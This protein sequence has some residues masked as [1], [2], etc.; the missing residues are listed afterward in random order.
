MPIDVFH[1]FFT[2]LGAPRH[3][4]L[5]GLLR[6]LST[7]ICGRVRGGSEN[8]W[9]GTACQFLEVFHQPSVALILVAKRND[10]ADEDEE[11]EEDPKRLAK[12]F[13]SSLSGYEGASRSTDWKYGS[14]E[15]WS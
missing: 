11:E 5:L 13:L 4:L 9:V 3:L 14:S 8:A 2:L 12:S 10:A 6:S 15:E 1:L 7:A